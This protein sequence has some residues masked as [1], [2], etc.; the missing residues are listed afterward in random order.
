MNTVANIQNTVT[1]IIYFLGG[2]AVMTFKLILN[3][4][5]GRN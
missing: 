2:I 1:I 5:S 3:E 4:N